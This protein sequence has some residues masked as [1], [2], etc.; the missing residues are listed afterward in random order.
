MPRLGN[1]KVRL[2]VCSFPFR[3]FKAI[4]ALMSAYS[5]HNMGIFV[6]SYH[7][8]GRTIELS[9]SR[10]HF[11]ILPMRRVRNWRKESFLK[12]DR[13]CIHSHS[14]A[15]QQVSTPPPSVYPPLHSLNSLQTLPSPLQTIIVLLG[16][17]SVSSFILCKNDISKL[18]GHTASDFPFG[19][20]RDR[21]NNRLGRGWHLK[22]AS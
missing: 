18:A 17:P 13:T 4:L 8:F 16:P 3:S 9:W 15:A 7:R 6:V 1:N 20:C 14:Q 5:Y 11:I 22:N 12:V 2:E 21:A 19:A 10:H